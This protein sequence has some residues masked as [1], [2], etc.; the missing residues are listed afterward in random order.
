MKQKWPNTR[1]MK[2]DP[3]VG[4]LLREEVGADNVQEQ[5]PMSKYTSFRVGGA[6]DWVVQVRDVEMLLKAIRAARRTK[7]PY[8]IIGGGSNILVSDAGIEGIVILNKADNYEL[9]EQDEQMILLAD[10]GVMLPKLAGELAKRGIA[11]MEWGV[12]VPGTVGGAVVQNAGAWGTEAKDRLISVEYIIPNQET[13]QTV[14]VEKLGMRYRGTNILDLLSHQRPTVLRASFRVWRDDP[15]AIRAR[16]VKY[17]TQRT[18]TQPRV[19]SGG[20]TFRNPPGDYA[21]RLIDVAGLKGHYIGNANFST[22]HANFIANHGGATAND[23]RAL[24]ELAKETVYD[25]FG[26][27]LH[28]EVEFVGYWG[29]K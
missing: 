24:I 17:R 7:L 28:T 25:Q 11:G 1:P 9:I 26:V 2:S 19:A 15:Q 10:S 8:R 21:G 6:A 27:H 13:I 18:A 12:G 5:Q 23:I 22:K 3:Q 4:I 16:N 14:P 20:S 29:E